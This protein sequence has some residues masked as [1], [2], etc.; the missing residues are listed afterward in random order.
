MKILE[1]TKETLENF[2]EPADYHLA[3]DNAV[4]RLSRMVSQI[5]TLPNEVAYDKAGVL[6]YYF[7]NNGEIHVLLMRPVA[8]K[9]HLP[10]PE[11]QTGKGTREWF[12]LK[13]DGTMGWIKYEVGKEGQDLTTLEPTF[14]SMV[15]EGMEELG[16]RPA[17]IRHIIELGEAGFVSATDNSPKR[18]WFYAAEVGDP[19]AF[20]P[21]SKK[22]ADTDKLAWYSEAEILKQGATGIRPD[23]VSILVDMIPVLKQRA[24]ELRQI[25]KKGMHY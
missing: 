17:N 21:P 7:G 16:L 11:F 13:P 1:Y 10:P 15:R 4:P 12:G 5:A 9:P 8:K 20:D 25:Q 3:A 19:E 18:M 24:L 6:P 14:T 2:V 22:H 23:Y